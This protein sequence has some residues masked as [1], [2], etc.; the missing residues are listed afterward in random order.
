MNLIS[1]GALSNRIEVAIRGLTPRPDTSVVRPWRRFIADGCSATSATDREALSKANSFHVT[2]V[3]YLSA[4]H[5]LDSDLDNLAKPVLDTIFLIAR[6]QTGDASLT[7]ALVRRND[8][9]V[10]R[11][12]LEKR[13][14]R[15]PGEEGVNITIDAIG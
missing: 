15:D 3:F 14:A 6:P 4:A 7:G 13:L 9:A 1:E 11:L 12:T 8:S 2:L 5:L 10:Y